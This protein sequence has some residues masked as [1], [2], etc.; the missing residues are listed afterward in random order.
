MCAGK[1]IVLST[2]IDNLAS[3]IINNSNSGIT[4][5]PEDHKGFSDAINKL[6]NDKELVAQY[7][8][9]AKLR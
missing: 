6:A 5:E 4:V 8:I 2:P 1:P 9:N 3:K 7:S